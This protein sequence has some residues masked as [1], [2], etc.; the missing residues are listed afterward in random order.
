MKKRHIFMLSGLMLLPHLVQAQVMRSQVYEPFMKAQLLQ[1]R[2]QDSAAIACLNEL[3]ELVP[4]FPPVYLRQADIYY[5]MYQRNGSKEALQGAVF[6]YRKYLTLEFNENLIK[7]PS[8]RL[9][10]LEDIL[11]VSHFEEDEMKESLASNTESIQIITD[12]IMADQIVE[13]QP[14]IKEIE[15]VPLVEV[16]NKKIE[17]ISETHPK[18]TLIPELGNPSFSFLSYYKLNPPT[19]PTTEVP[20]VPQLN[21]K[22]MTGHWVSD[23]MLGDGRE[24]WIFDFK[25]DGND[26]LIVTFSNHSG[27]VNVDED[28]STPFRRALVVTKSYLQK[29]NI[30]S[31][32][33]YEVLNER[34]RAKVDPSGF[35]FK[36][37][38]DKNY[39]AGN[40]LFKW[41]KSLVNN[42]SGVIPFGPSISNYVNNYV[43]QKENLDRT[44]N[45]TIVYTF[46]CK[47][48]APGILSCDI[49][50]MSNYVDEK[51]RNKSKAGSSFTCSLF[52]TEN[53]YTFGNNEVMEEEHE[54]LDELF[55]KVKQ[56]AV[57]DVNYNYP[58]AILYFYGIGT[59]QDEG[60]AVECMNVLGLNRS[61]A[62]AK[63]WLASYFYHKAYTDDVFNIILRRK[64]IK[65]AQFWSSLMKSQKHKE[66]YGVKG[67]M[68]ISDQQ[69]DINTTMQ[70][71]ALYF[72]QKGDE[73]GDVYSTY[74]LGY[75]YLHNEKPNLQ[76]AQR[77]LL[78]AANAG[79]EDA[80]Y[81]LALSALV[82]KDFDAYVFNLHLAA[83]MG[84]PE[85]YDEIAKGYSIGINR[86]FKLNPVES[87]KMK[88][89][90]KQAA[91]DDWMTV[92]L[93]YGYKI[94]SYL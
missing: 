7:E 32:T 67:D 63:A 31:D 24:Q 12:Q 76:E 88:R 85:A 6:M 83:D 71:S 36:I 19:V 4:S 10:K 33:K 70:D 62:R 9:R 72:Y 38:V 23:M 74:R 46:N 69:R 65:S 91:K 41:G 35:T 94:D 80:I 86:G 48:K 28:D 92:L 18:S 58:L 90:A 55:E 82:S 17:S 51:G 66:W 3:A 57:K 84:C 52:K 34:V 30:M 54:K 64:Y 89:F 87:T 16:D 45:A 37:E 79:N 29:T 21:S 73:A 13:S 42:L 60:K 11:Q 49:T 47:S 77:L 20:S 43:E 61:D 93:S 15:L 39:I 44:K 5:E 2:G 27:I 56:D 78:K 1:R 68:C 25:D 59:K 75:M 81:E 26:D 8:E 40:A 50:S 14:E 53:G 22:D